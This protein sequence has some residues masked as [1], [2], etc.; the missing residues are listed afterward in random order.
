LRWVDQVQ[1]KVRRGPT[2]TKHELVAS[3]AA[4]VNCGLQVTAVPSAPVAL[5]MVLDRH[6]SP[7]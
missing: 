5:R 4:R 2:A 1:V 6:A 7:N 3:L